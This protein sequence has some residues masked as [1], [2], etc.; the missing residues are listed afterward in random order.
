M[1]HKLDLHHNLYATAC[2]LLL[3]LS[4]ISMKPYIFLYLGTLATY[5]ATVC[6][7]AT[8]QTYIQGSNKSA[9]ITTLE[10]LRHVKATCDCH[11]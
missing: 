8:M 9:S 4:S 5:S 1:L 3:L 7:V 2:K 6:K 10:V 11:T